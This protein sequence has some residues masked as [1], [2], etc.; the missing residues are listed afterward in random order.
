M[1]N[2]SGNCQVYASFSKS[3]SSSYQFEAT[4]SITINPFDQWN[5]VTVTVNNVI[6][7]YTNGVLATTTTRT[8]P[9]IIYGNG[10]I[11]TSGDTDLRWVSSLGYAPTLEQG[12]GGTWRPYNGDFGLGFMY[13]RILTAEEV[14]QNYNAQ[15]SRF[16]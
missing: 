12:S 13:N 5:N 10:N 1:K 3:S 14:L 2:N 9:N 11:N 16:I 4:N 6:S 7:L 8:V 15:K